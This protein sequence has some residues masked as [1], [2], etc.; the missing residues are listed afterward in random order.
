MAS[1]ISQARE[2]VDNSVLVDNGDLIQGSPMG[3]FMAAKGLENGRV[4]PVYKVMNQL[5]YDVGNIGNHEFNYGLTFLKK[6]TDGARFPY[7]NANVVDAATGEHLYQPYIIK[8]QSFKDSDGHMQKVNVG[9]IGFV[10]PQIMQWDRKTS[11]ARWLLVTFS[12]PLKSMC[13]R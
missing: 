12:R 13:Q 5:D 11:K 10:P 9:Y 1:L 8:K 7:I 4:H 6:A 2:E 3:D